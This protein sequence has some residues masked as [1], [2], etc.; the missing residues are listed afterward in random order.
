MMVDRAFLAIPIPAELRLAVAQLQERLSRQERN[1]R[2]THPETLHLTLHF[3]GGLS[4]ENLVKIK[5]SMLSVGLRT[6]PFQVEIGELGAF[7]NSRRPRVV[8][9][10]LFPQQPL[11]HL[12]DLW[13]KELD[14]RDLPGAEKSFS[15]HLT[16]GRFRQGARRLD[17]L[18]AEHAEDSRIGLC[19]VDCLVLYQSRLGSGRAEHSP[20]FT[21]RLDG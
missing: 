3:L 10:G 6:E 7:P 2:W 13:Q 12:Y 20:L 11:K 5:A 18:F 4:E 14:R 17:K 16:I 15:P 8:W 21:A 9:L 1:L 19:P